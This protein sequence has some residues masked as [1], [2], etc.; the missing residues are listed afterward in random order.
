MRFTLS[1]VSVLL[2]LTCV[3]TAGSM[4]SESGE[5]VEWALQQGRACDTSWNSFVESQPDG[6]GVAVACARGTIARSPLRAET[7]LQ[8]NGKGFIHKANLPFLPV[9]TKDRGGPARGVTRLDSP[10]SARLNVPHSRRRPFNSRT[11]LGSFRRRRSSATRLGVTSSHRI[12]RVSRT[13]RSASGSFSRTI[14]TR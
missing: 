9:S 11:E 2:V 6:V 3:S 8:A 13:R 14:K 7:G 12:S 5:F 1:A 10:A 4:A